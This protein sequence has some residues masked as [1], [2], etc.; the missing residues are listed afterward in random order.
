MTTNKLDQLR[1]KVDRI[2]RELLGSLNRRS[3]IVLKIGKIK[4]ESHK[5]IYAPGREKAVLGRL[6]KNNRGPFPE[7]ALRAVFREILS[8]SRSL[9]SPLK[10]C[11][12]G[13]EASFTNLA[14]LKHFGRSTEL[15]P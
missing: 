9:Q 8:A 14:A 10:V 1:K 4:K 3:E 5:E 6:A 11:Y 15:M 12:F 13:P 7:H 2:D